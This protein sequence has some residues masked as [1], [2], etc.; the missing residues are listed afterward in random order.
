MYPNREALVLGTET[1]LCPFLT[2]PPSAD[3]EIKPNE[4]GQEGMFHLRPS[5]LCKLLD[6]QL[7]W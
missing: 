6:V 3:P 1:V 2:P 5:A 4:W 7:T